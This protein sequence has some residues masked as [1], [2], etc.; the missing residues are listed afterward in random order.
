MSDQYEYYG[1]ILP[2]DDDCAFTCK[3]VYDF[4]NLTDEMVMTIIAL[5][6]ELVRWRQALIKYLPD[7]WAEGLRM[8]ILNNLSR[9]YEGDTAY[10]LYVRY[11]RGE[12]PQQTEER[13]KRLKRL[14][15]GTD[16]TSI[17]YL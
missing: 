2:Y 13:H 3:T 1:E 16:E 17:T 4:M 14:M 8:D 10:D 6:D 7:R 12:D 9:D 15:E 5:E 11:K